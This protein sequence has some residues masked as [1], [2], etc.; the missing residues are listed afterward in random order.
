MQLKEH[1]CMCGK[2]RFEKGRHAC[3]QSGKYVCSHLHLPAS[4]KKWREGGGVEQKNPFLSNPI[5]QPHALCTLTYSPKAMWRRVMGIYIPSK[6]QRK[7]R[8]VKIIL[9]FLPLSNFF[10]A[11]FKWNRKKILSSPLGL[12]IMHWIKKPHRSGCKATVHL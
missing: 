4:A 5:M 11:F 3:A 7:C 1:V 9:F 8:R 6:I 2:I 10:K 12:K